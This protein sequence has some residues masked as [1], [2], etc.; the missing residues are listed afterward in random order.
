[1]AFRFLIYSTGTTFAETI[2]R[3]SATNN[4]GA[5]EASYWS[6]F[7]IPEIQPVY[8][9]R[10][11]GGTGAEDV[12][13]NTDQ[14][15]SN[16]LN[17]IAPT[18]EKDDFATVGYVTGITENKIDIVTGATG[19]IGTF[20]A[21]G[22]LEDSGYAISDVT[23]GTEYIFT[24]SG[25]TQVFTGGTNPTEIIIYSTPPTGTS[26]AWGNI[27]GTLSAQTDLQNALDAKLDETVFT[28]YTATTQPILD[29]ALTGVTNLGTGTTLGGTSGRNVTFKSISVL[30]GLSLSGDAD[31][32]IISGQTG[33]TGSGTITGGT[34]GLTTV[35]QNIE[36][37]G[38][39]T[40]LTSIN[41]QGNFLTFYNNSSIVLTASAMTY[42][43]LN[44]NGGIHYS[45]DYSADYVARSL[46]DAAY[47]TGL[48]SNLTP[49]SLFTGY[50][51][52][53]DSRLDTIESDIIYLS[54]QTDLKLN[55][56]D[57]NV[58]SGSTDTRITNIETNITELSGQTAAAITGATNGL[59][60]VG[61]DVLLGGALTQDTVISGVTHSF[62]I[63]T[64]DIGLQ[65]SGIGGIDIIDAGAGGINIESDGS[66][67]SLIGNTALG[68]ERTK[69]EI[70]ETVMKITD[71]RGTPIGMVYAADYT[72]TFIP[73]SLITKRYVD[74]VATGLKP[75]A[76]VEAA[77]TTNID[78]TGGTFG[79]TVDGY[80]V[81]DGDRILVKDQTL[82]EQNGI[83]DYSGGSNT[84]IR[85]SDFDGNPGGEV[86]DG[87]IVPVVTGDT[88]YNTLWV[89]ITP[90]PIT[91]GT[92]DLEFTL[93]SSPVGLVA[94]VG[95]DISGNTI[96]VDG[97]SLAG[98]S[99][100]WSGN[101]FNVDPT[102]GNLAT[103]LALKL[104][105]SDFNTYSANTNNLITGNTANI[106]I[107][108]Q[109][110]LDNKT[111][112]T[113]NYN[114]ITGNTADISYISGVTDTKLDIN[115]FT[116]Y[117]GATAPNEI[118][119]THTGGTDLNTILAT[120][121]EWD[122][123]EV[124]GA[125]SSWTGSSE[126]KIL[127]A[128]LYEINYNIPYNITAN[129]SIGVGANVILNNTTVI[130]VTAAAGLA[131][132][133]DGAASIGLPTVIVSL[134]ENDVLNLAAFRT[135]QAGTATSSL[136]GSILIKKKNTL[137]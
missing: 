114:L 16:Y 108:T 8:L 52:T 66:V 42:Q 23:G 109:Q 102:T 105:V 9:W 36:L 10:V 67:I 121:I 89:L 119:L 59:T 20:V 79:G 75:K 4:P 13:P 133:S 118:F 62:K 30:G 19:N 95:I 57:F 91:V 86:V 93:F 6:D 35:G 46:V 130:D 127:E 129:S 61:K 83:Y 55:I 27:T 124:S 45:A 125:A 77:T 37:G 11:T 85:S 69:L 17:D 39:L 65:S 98:S 25:G 29:V 71:S 110:I 49:L 94:G 72:T 90:D 51:A 1:M 116:G 21:S 113:A 64:S 112:I 38:D 32:L 7:V 26:V 122:S 56:T 48:T 123:E 103:A 111:G 82:G 97:A 50:T 15:I 131:V 28:G 84:F 3:E 2:V 60:K 70:G 96:S 120:A 76:S 101:T 68:A 41:G 58:Y 24:G 126:I 135:H 73:E 12:V 44:S 14:N 43:D 40:K 74:A 53:T 63:N 100:V 5:N 137:Q 18:P 54:G 31:N 88:Q 33:G 47:V 107:N 34:N 104:D 78:L 132:K 128:G 99:I 134:A 92:T 136:T 87:N 80:T 117:T 81:Q 115:T 22:N 106:V